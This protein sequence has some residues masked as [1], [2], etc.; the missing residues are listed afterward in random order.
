MNRARLRQQRL[1]APDNPLMTTR[2]ALPQAL[3]SVPRFSA[4]GLNGVISGG[5]VETLL[6][7]GSSLDSVASVVSSVGR[8]AL[9][10]IP[11]STLA[12]TTRDGT[13]L[14]QV[15]HRIAQQPLHDGLDEGSRQRLLDGLLLDIADPGR[16]VIQSV[17]DTC[18]AASWNYELARDWPAEYAQLVGGLASENGGAQMANGDWL[19]LQQEYLQQ[20]GDDRRTFSSALFQGAALDFAN[21]RV[22]YDA[23]ED[24]HKSIFMP[25][26]LPIDQNGNLPAAI[27]GTSYQ[28][29]VSADGTVHLPLDVLRRYPTDGSQPPLM[30][31]LKLDF[32]EANHVVI[33]EKVE[34]DRVFYR[35]PWGPSDLP[36]GAPMDEG[37]RVEDPAQGLESMSFDELRR[38]LK[39]THIP[40]EAL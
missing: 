12:S 33:F 2:P 3:P 9:D 15:L 29:D 37:G 23:A 34:G 24:K 40:R 7:E 36:A 38:R 17:Y 4:E 8:E 16:N 32:V 30:L 10:A 11:V 25:T 14:A 18:Q 20:W 26:G 6:G 21:G 27:Y 31:S 28:E 22:D 19:E 5:A 39:G 1:D 13:T 35:N